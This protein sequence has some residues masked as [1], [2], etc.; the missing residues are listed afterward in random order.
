MC[1]MQVKAT[2]RWKFVALS[3]CIG[4]GKRSQINDLSILLK[5]LLQE[6]QIKL[7]VR[8][9]KEIIKKKT[10]IN[11]IKN[12]KLKRKSIKPKASPLKKNTI[13]KPLAGLIKKREETLV[14][15]NYNEKGHHCSPYL[16]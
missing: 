11:E 1:E 14:T 5:K 16:N 4:K 6:E 7:K 3:V 12:R 8:R 9:S 13:Q 15:S 10:E 2:L